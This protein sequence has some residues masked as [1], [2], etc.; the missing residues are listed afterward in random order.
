MSFKQKTTE[1]NHIEQGTTAHNHIE[2]KTTE[3]VVQCSVYLCSDVKCS[4]KT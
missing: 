2:Q 3:P 1:Q 4:I